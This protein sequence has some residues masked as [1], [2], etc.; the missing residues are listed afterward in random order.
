MRA[1]SPT[2][3]AILGVAAVSASAAEL[4][5]ADLD[6]FETK[7][8]PIFADTCY[9]CHNAADGKLKGG[10]ALDTKEGW[11]KGGDTGP[12]IVPGSPEKSL[13]IKS[14]QY[15]DPDLQMPPKGEKLTDAQIAELVAW[16]KR[17]APDPRTGTA[18]AKYKGGTDAAKEH[19]AFQPVK[20][21]TPPTVNARER[22]ST[23]VDNFILQKLEAKGLTMNAPADR[24]TLIRRVY[25]DLVGVPPTPQEVDAFV[26][27][28]S[29]KAFEKVVDTLLASPHYGERWGRYWL[30]VARYSDTKG[31]ANRREDPRFP[32]AWTYRDYVINSFNEDKP[33]DQFIIEQIAADKVAGSDKGKLAALGFLTL[34]DRF[35]GNA[36][37]VINDRIDVVTKGFLGLTV[38]CAR[39]HDH[40]FDP[41][42]TEDYYSLHGVFSS[43]MEPTEMPL[44]ET[45]NS[46]DGQYR[47]YLAERSRLMTEMHRSADKEINA[48]L[49]EFRKKAGAYLT[50]VYLDGKARTDLDKEAKLNRD[51]VQLVQNRIRRAGDRDPVIGPWNQ[52]ARAWKA[53]E[54][55]FPAEAKKIL[56]KVIENKPDPKKKNATTPYNPLIASMFKRNPSPTRLDQVATY[57]TALFAT[58]EAQWS[59]QLKSLE[60][61]GGFARPFSNPQLEEIRNTPVKFTTTSTMEV[62]DVM[63]MVP[64]R[65]QGRI[66][67]QAN[68]L[69]QLELT[70][71]GAPARATVLVDKDKPA[72]SPVFVRGEATN[73][74]K[75]VPRQFLQVLS[76]PARKPFTIGSGRLELARAIADKN[77]PLT[78][79]VIANRVWLHHFGEGIVTTPD[80]FGTMAD[81]PSHP[82]L[83]DYL[84]GYLTDN[85]WSLKK[86]HRQ[87]LL[88][89]TYQQSS[90]N[91]PRFAQVD[92]FNR[93]LWRANIRK[94]EFEAVRDSLLAIGG[95]LDLEVGGRPVNITSEPY[96]NRRSVYGFID[97]ANLAE[98]MTHF[99]FA[100]PDLPTGKRYDTIVPQQALFMMNSPQVIEVTRNLVAR[101]EFKNAK[102]DDARIEALYSIIYQRKPRP[103]ER[104]LG[105]EF[106]KNAGE[107]DP[108]FARVVPTAS[109]TKK[110]A[111]QKKAAVQSM[112]GASMGIVNQGRM[113]DRRPSTN[114][115]KYAQTLLLA[116]EASYVN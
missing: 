21:H 10:L 98:V 112:R 62:N 41:I 64:V 82:E 88:S 110:A 3:L 111:P 35:D 99:D 68:R 29:P 95:K 33:F 34:G 96:S 115:E 16:V 23:P 53:N 27:D 89:S 15:T 66:R 30:D 116:N 113:V 46:S 58:V 38:A 49:S 45:I 18:N 51:T 47:A 102:T 109:T 74:G 19:W 39:C 79:R 1:F 60:A 72:N 71:P 50:V 17:G 25:F 77:N 97:R 59:A 86:L 85:G 37:D 104:M 87:I 20:R 31:S 26:N 91:N 11:M 63:A 40:F 75:P 56:A 52:L 9:K 48:L 94:L 8:R 14:I 22:V 55:T 65:L 70:H 69:S 84:A 92:P 90:E 105:H 4:A 6:F 67:G 101:P 12:A 43:S 32:Y 2:T 61:R 106:L 80:D 13:L 73:K 83:L 57:Y 36:N 44:L 28:K 93:L 108:V 100:T 114:W 24:Y 107:P 103:E 7:I 5:K 78:A 76:G 81:P 42:P 54:K